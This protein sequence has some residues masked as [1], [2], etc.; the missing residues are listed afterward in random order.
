[1]TARKAAFLSSA[2]LCLLL[3]SPAH[4]AEAPKWQ[5]HIE[6]EGKW[7][8]ERSL[9]EL[10][11][12]APVWQNENTLVFTDFRG[13][14]DD[15]DS[16]EG[17]FG[18]GLRHQINNEW[19]VGGY[20]FYDRRKTP[21]DN[22]Y[23]QA[24]MGIEALSSNIEAR[25]NGYLPESEEKIV[26][27]ATAAS[28][29]ASASGGNFQLVT[30]SAGGVVER[31]LP[32]VDVEIGYNFNL[33][34]KWDL[35]AY[36]GAYYFD[37]DGYESISGPRGRIEL[38][39]SDVPYLGEGSKLTLGFETQTDDVRGG[40]S[41]GVA[42]IRIPL[43]YNNAQSPSDLS[44]IDRR[45]TARINRDVDI[46]SASGGGLPTTTTETATVTT[47]SGQAVSQ[48]TLIDASGDISADVAAGELLVI[49]D[50]S[51]GN[52]NAANGI[53]V[54]ANQ[55]IMSGGQNV[56]LTGT[57]SGRTASVTLP[58]SRATV[59]LTAVNGFFDVDVANATLKDFD[60]DGTGVGIS[61]VV[62]DDN[63]TD[64]QID[65]LNISNLTNAGILTYG[66]TD[67]TITNTTV[68]NVDYGILLGNG[69][70][71]V[72]NISGAMT[73]TNAITNVCFNIGAVNG[74]TLQVNGAAC[75]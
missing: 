59:A 43:N 17:N 27:P 42:R 40:Q 19:I 4:A 23:H 74:S 28:T 64:T 48:Y 20:G 18:L 39:Y 24:T 26:T 2:C 47:A 45:M 75:P 13:R 67:T 52:I 8:T 66:A 21:S 61:G 33:P 49:L 65:G 16:S 10:G 71:V 1:M 54:I 25:V 58:G 34:K 15:Q 32:G 68:D 38:G 12:F 29:T 11:L 62:L 50:G 70:A 22:L 63:A 14:L 51:S 73:V 9:G 6:A 69:G 56:T 72:N 60:I 46:V 53:H 41:W 57:T 30:T 55:T 3:S 7:G 44:A 36:G 5:G 37:A 31:A 35:W